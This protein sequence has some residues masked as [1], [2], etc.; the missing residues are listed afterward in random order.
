M[1]FNVK[2]HWQDSVGSDRLRQVEG[3]I[4]TGMLYQ[5]FKCLCSCLLFLLLPPPIFTSFLFPFPSFGFFRFLPVLFQLHMQSPPVQK[6]FH[7]ILTEAVGAED[8]DEE[9]TLADDVILTEYMDLSEFLN[10]SVSKEF[11]KD[12]NLKIMHFNIDNLT[13]KFDSFETLIS[14]DLSASD[15]CPFFDLI[16]ISETHLCSEQGNSNQTSRSENEI[17]F[18]LPNYYFVGKSRV[19]MKKGGC[20]FFIRKD[21]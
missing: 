2:N 4:R 1:R 12:G 11:N 19:N 18:S 21:L 5:T 17:Q 3:P 6:N 9:P 15:G 10:D 8:D 14:K 7:D 13:T 16:S 20:G